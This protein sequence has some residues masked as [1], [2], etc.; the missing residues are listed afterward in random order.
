[1]I[2]YEL[3]NDELGIS[4]DIILYHFRFFF[5]QV[6][7]NTYSRAQ[8][9]ERF[10]KIFQHSMKFQSIKLPILAVMEATIKAPRL[11]G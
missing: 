10:S 9:K 4:F 1:M 8:N 11:V 3:Y 2:L 6:N 7:N 5:L